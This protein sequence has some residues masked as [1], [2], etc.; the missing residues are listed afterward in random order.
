MTR[1]ESPWVLPSAAAFLEEAETAARGGI[2]HLRS[3]G[4]MPGGFGEA[5]QDRFAATGWRG[6][7]VVPD[8][9]EAPVVALAR[10]LGVRPPSL[11]GLL[12]SEFVDQ[13]AIVDLSRLPATEGEE[14][15]SFAGRFGRERRGQDSGLV[16]ALI[17]GEGQCDATLSW[18]RRLRG[19][20]AM[21]WAELHAPLERLRPLGALAAA[22]AVELCGWRLDLGEAIARASA[23]DLLD[24]L[25]WLARRE[26]PVRRGPTGRR[27]ACPLHLRDAGDTDELRLRVWR[28]Q[29][30]SLFPWVEEIRQAVLAR[31]RKRL[32]PP[33]EFQRRL[34]VQSVDDFELGAIA[35]QLNPAL[36]REEAEALWSLARIRNALAHRFP[37][38]RPDLERAIARFHSWLEV[39]SG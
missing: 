15:L 12:A 17:G 30:A 9:G 23:A 32:S 31:Y 10:T 7:T 13:L 34:G 38:E 5:L 22:L 37:A 35:R 20:D 27:L 25:G 11:R 1:I 8:D 16:L 33:D 14:W 18:Q 2:I 21:V 39:P 4:T 26:E 29:L 6:A 3:D 19:I 28:A 36:R 24:P